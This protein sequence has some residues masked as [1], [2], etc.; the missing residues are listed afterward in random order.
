MMRK[1]RPLLPAPDARQSQGDEVL[2]GIP[3]SAGIKQL[4][5]EHNAQSNT[6]IDPCAPGGLSSFVTWLAE[7]PARSVSGL[8]RYM[9]AV[10]NER[11]DLQAHYPEVKS[12]ELT[13]FAWWA[14][15]AGRFEA[16]TFRLF[17]H[18]VH[19]LSIF[20]EVVLVN[21]GNDS[22]GFFNA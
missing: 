4:L 7:V 16:P 19:V 6:V 12:G 14:H 11:N 17:G 3:F 8:P 9:Q 20:R 10:Y 18:E 13:R 15:V 21:C 22:I 1:R 2:P 5:E